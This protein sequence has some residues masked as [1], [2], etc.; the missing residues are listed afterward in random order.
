MAK[1]GIRT[2]WWWIAAAVAAITGKGVYDNR[3]RKPEKG[4][5]SEDNP[6]EK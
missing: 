3:R 6:D 1:D 2:W 4:D 5:N